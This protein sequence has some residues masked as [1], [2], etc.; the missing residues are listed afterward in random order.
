M[1]ITV[2]PLTTPTFT[3][4]PAI[5]SGG[6]LNALPTTSTNSVAGSW[7]P[8]LDNTRTTTYTF[9]PTS[10]ASPACATTTTMSITVNPLTTPTFTQ[11]ESFC[12]NATPA[13]LPTTS[14][15]D[16]VGTWNPSIISTATVGNSI[17][18][19]TPASTA[20]PSCATT[21][22]MSIMVNPLPNVSL[23]AFNNVC[24]NAGIVN[25]TGGSPAG[26]TYSGSS[27]SNNSFN[28]SIG[29]GSYPITYSY[30]NSSGCSSSE[31]KNLT[32]ISCSSSSLVE[33][34]ERGIIL[35]PNPT[36]NSFIVETSE[37]LNS[38]EF[39]IHDVSGRVLS[40]G[41]IIGNTTTIQ[42]S[43]LSTGTY[44]FKLLETNRTLKFVK[45]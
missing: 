36:S 4:V 32:V 43:T 26:G 10:T 31:T 16:I 45:Q 6:T 22:T 18:T 8:A 2:N 9:T 17:Y 30:T 39:I 5:C 13:S 14:N 41:T 38:K 28:P 44:Y 3:Q 19:F 37:E 34:N 20:V 24:D 7:S 21:V 35:Y 33:L 27:V 29:V 15:N 23:K 11:I 40:T 12:Q 1:S 42:V 25:L